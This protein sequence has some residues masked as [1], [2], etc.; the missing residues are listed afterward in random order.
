MRK[1]LE[2]SHFLFVGF[3]HKILIKGLQRD[4]RRVKKN[5]FIYQTKIIKIS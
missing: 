3:E 5:L 2:S 1:H 4:Q